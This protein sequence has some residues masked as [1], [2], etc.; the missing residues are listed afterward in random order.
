[1]AEQLQTTTSEQEYTPLDKL[2]ITSLDTVKVLSD[3]LR[4]QMLESMLDRPVTVKQLAADLKIPQ[5]KLYYHMN[6]L[7]E[8]GL[9]R[10]VSTRVVSGIIEKQY[11]VAAYS[12][13]IDKTLFAAPGGKGISEEVNSLLQTMFDGARL[14]LNKSVEAGLVDIT[15]LG[16]PGEHKPT[17]LILVRSLAHVPEDKVEELYRKM[18]EVIKEF[19]SFEAENPD[20]PVHGLM[21]LMYP[22]THK[23]HPKRRVSKQDENGATSS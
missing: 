11:W 16:D 15:K 4:L 7:E 5:T 21:V 12:I 9:V 10:V 23:I 6:T 14:D 1:M 8:H 3:P 22:T 17:K 2:T 19:D 13:S 20:A 18:Y